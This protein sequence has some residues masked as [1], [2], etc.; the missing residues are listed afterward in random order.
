M[1]T[2]IP[3]E[4][5]LAR[6]IQSLEKH[7]KR[8][9]ENTIARIE[10]A[11]QRKRVPELY[12]DLYE[13][14][15]YRADGMELI[16]SHKLKEGE[17]GLSLANIQ[18]TV[19]KRRKPE[20]GF[21]IATHNKAED[22]SESA[23]AASRKLRPKDML[24]VGT[25]FLNGEDASSKGRLLMF[26]VNR[27]ESYT[28]QGGEYTAFQMQLIAEKT[29]PGPVTAVAALE[30]YVVC[31][32][33][34]QVHV[35]K[36]VGDE[37]VHLSFA[38]AQLYI[39]SI[40]TLKQYVVTA[41]MVK[42]IQFLF[43][44]ERNNSVN[45]LGKDYEHLEAYATEYL[46]D[47]DQ[48]SIVLSDSRGNIQLMDYVHVSNPESRGGTRLLS[49][50]GVCISTRINQFL[51][52]RVIAPSYDNTD[53]TVT[54][55]KADT[56]AGT[57]ATLF[58]AHDGSIGGV[59]PIDMKTFHLLLRLLEVLENCDALERYAGLNPKLFSAFRPQSQG[60][61]M[62]DQRLVSCHLLRQ[63]WNLDHV[64]A[65]EV[66]EEAGTNVE[67]IAQIVT[68]LHAVLDQF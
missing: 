35:Y 22:G 42:S 55:T 66:A 63:F 45:F 43:W 4:E 46:I 48:L 31:G 57:H 52:A 20:P 19:F 6:I 29:C 1:P 9:Y 53:S 50:G 38:F 36:L 54:K 56:G 44:R 25:G 34:P 62:L 2:L 21:V 60:H 28:E 40:A 65:M 41:D 24:V 12:E 10:A 32:V 7:D 17:V 13:L 49:N 5:R 39:A 15:L 14:R 8:H 58:P 37:I 18:V 26:E 11:R 33:G 59:V 23:F 51:R 61:Q 3:R 30:G 27:Q 68:H 16:R 47:N 64:T 67:Q